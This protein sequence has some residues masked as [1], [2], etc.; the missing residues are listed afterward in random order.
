MIFHQLLAGES[1]FPE[2]QNFAEVACRMVTNEEQS[3]FPNLSFPLFE[4]PYRTVWQKNPAI[5]PLLKTL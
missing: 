4:N 1:A 5:S 3:Q 2:E